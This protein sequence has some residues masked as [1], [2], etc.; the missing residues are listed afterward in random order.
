MSHD[1]ARDIYHVVYDDRQ[2][3]VDDEATAELRAS[4]RRA[5][6]ARSKPFDEFC[7]EW[8]TPEP[9]PH[10]TYFGSWADTRVIHAQ[11]PA[12]GLSVKMDADKLQGIYMPNPKDLRIAELEAQIEAMQKPAKA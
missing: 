7:K 9:A 5:R 10:L 12:I 4:E 1:I 8:V 2:L 11:N 6:L 3:I